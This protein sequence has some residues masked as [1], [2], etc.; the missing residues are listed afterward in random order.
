[1]RAQGEFTAINQPEKDVFAFDFA[2]VLVDGETLTG[3]VGTQWTIGLMAGADP[4]PVSRLSGPAQLQGTLIAQAVE[5]ALSG[6]TYWVA[7]EVT[8]SRNRKLLLWAPL[9]VGV[10]GGCGDAGTC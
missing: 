2:S 5:G 10:I 8:T 6:V 9:P 4:T 3:I 1:M 7:G